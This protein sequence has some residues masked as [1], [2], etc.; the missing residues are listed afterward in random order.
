MRGYRSAGS[1]NGDPALLYRISRDREGFGRAAQ[2]G[3]AKAT[4]DSAY[5]GGRVFVGQK[6]LGYGLVQ[7]LGGIDLAIKE[8]RLLAKIG[9]GR[10]IELFSLN[11]GDSR[12]LSQ[13][14]VRALA[15]YFGDIG[16]VRFWAIE[17]SLWN[18][19]P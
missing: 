1:P 8:A 10:D 12:L 3:I 13:P 18:V 16:Q 4:V 15:E 14:S 2:T 6:A 7:G 5:G 9:E 19:E 11:T 17:P